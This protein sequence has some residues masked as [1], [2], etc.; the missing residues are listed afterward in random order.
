MVYGT[1]KVLMGYTNPVAIGGPTMH[2]LTMID[3]IF[4]LLLIDIYSRFVS[5]VWW[6]FFNFPPGDTYALYLV[7]RPSQ[8]I[9]VDCIIG[10]KSC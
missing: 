2:G 3:F 8:H 5:S 6:I 7:V 10:T 4:M 9:F 1:Y